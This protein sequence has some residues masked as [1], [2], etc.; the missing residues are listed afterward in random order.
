VPA[1][2]GADAEIAIAEIAALRIG[3]ER[4]ARK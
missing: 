3:I 1:I 2:R 4:A